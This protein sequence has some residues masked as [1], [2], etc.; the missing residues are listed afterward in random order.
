MTSITEFVRV[1]P[2]T[3]HYTTLVVGKHVY[4]VAHVGATTADGIYTIVGKTETC[5]HVDGRHIH[6]HLLVM[7]YM[8]PTARPMTD[9]EV[10]AAEYEEERVGHG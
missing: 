1:L 9:D 3:V 6:E 4:D 2:S 8:A 5:Y 10:R 7:A